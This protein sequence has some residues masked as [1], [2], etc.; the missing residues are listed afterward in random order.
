MRYV[1][2]EATRPHT[3]VTTITNFAQYCTM[4]VCFHCVALVYYACTCSY[5]VA[6][7]IHSF[8]VLYTAKLA[9]IRE[10]TKYRA[11]TSVATII[12]AVLWTIF[13]LL[14]GVR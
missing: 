6:G 8:A 5:T 10:Y 12:C 14:R 13:F 11:C 3:K 2:G 4:G 7:P 1:R 9:G